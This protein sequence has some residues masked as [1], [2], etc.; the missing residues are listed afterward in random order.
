MKQNNG[1][2]AEDLALMA[3]VVVLLGDFL[4]FLSILKER[5]EKEDKGNNN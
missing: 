4:A 2:S 5:Q 1:F 3:A